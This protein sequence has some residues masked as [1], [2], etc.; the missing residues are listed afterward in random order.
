MTFDVESNVPLMCA[1]ILWN[2][3]VL[4]LKLLDRWLFDLILF[5]F[6]FFDGG[7]TFEL[8]I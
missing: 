7:M 4:G 6:L 3:S 8:T 2:C 5:I 1:T